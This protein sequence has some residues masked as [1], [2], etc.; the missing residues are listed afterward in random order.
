MR[1][2][3]GS[4]GKAVISKHQETVKTCPPPFALQGSFSTEAILY[5]QTKW[6]ENSA[7]DSDCNQ[8]QPENEHT[9]YTEKNLLSMRITHFTS[10]LRNLKICLQVIYGN[11]SGSWWSS[12]IILDII[13]I[14]CRTHSHHSS[15]KSLHISSLGLHPLC[16]RGFTAAE[17]NTILPHPPPGSTFGGSWHLWWMWSSRRALTSSVLVIYPGT[18]TSHHSLKHAQLSHWKQPVPH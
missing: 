14:Q 7:F 9:K 11:S 16:S 18:V 2:F 3:E 5:K 13:F 17:A 4:F 10:H 12:K 1:S 6:C 15:K 8:D